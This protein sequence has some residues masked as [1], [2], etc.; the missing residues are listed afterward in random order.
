MTE[1]ERLTK[2]VK[3]ALNGKMLVKTADTIAPIIA[4]YLAAKG[5]IAPPCKAGD[6]VYVIFN[7]YITEAMV[8]AIVYYD[9]CGRFELNIKVKD[10]TTTGLK[11]AITKEYTFD[12]IYITQE[13]AEKALKERNDKNVYK[14]FRYKK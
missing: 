6:M 5:V 3:E 14:K 12:D 9:E 13:E 4:D 7:G 2:L 11:T 1:L 10:E 8:L